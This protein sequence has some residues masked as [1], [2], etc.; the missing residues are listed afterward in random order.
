MKRRVC[1]TVLCLCFL[2]SI[3]ERG[4]TIDVGEGAPKYRVA[5]SSYAKGS[6]IFLLHISLGEASVTPECLRKLVL[7]LRAKYSAHYRRV[8]AE[9]FTSYRA[10]KISNF[11]YGQQGYGEL[12][13][14]HRARYWFDQDKGEEYLRFFPL[15]PVKGEEMQY[16][17]LK[18]TQKK[19]K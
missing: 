7:E 14:A 4:L 12:E 9:V 13:S 16:I 3:A 17:C 8:L 5:I 10:A 6:G 1:L 2:A 19:V 15:P 18:E 11:T